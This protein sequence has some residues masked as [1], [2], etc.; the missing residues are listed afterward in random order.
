MHQTGYN[1][2][3]P[4]FFPSFVNQDGPIPGLREEH[5]PEEEH[6]EMALD[7]ELFEALDDAI[8]TEANSFE[9]PTVALNLSVKHC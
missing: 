5:V 7:A 9:I 6:E 3:Q 8:E 1:Q 2:D 4:S